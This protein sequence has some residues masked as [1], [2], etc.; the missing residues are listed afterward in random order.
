MGM[1]GLA[2]L[3]AFGAIATVAFWRFGATRSLDRADGVLRHA[4]E[5]VYDAA[6][7]WRGLLVRNIHGPARVQPLGNVERG[8]AV[9]AGGAG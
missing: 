2:S 8:Y 1:S 5:H 6:F 3:T 7:S 4:V 9:E